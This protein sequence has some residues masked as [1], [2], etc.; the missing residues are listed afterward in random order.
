MADP[1]AYINGSRLN[2]RQ[3]LDDMRRR[4][5]AYAGKDPHSVDRCACTY[6]AGESVKRG[7]IVVVIAC[8]LCP[9]E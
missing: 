9:S 7:E 2:D 3:G 6:A 8:R 1:V 5:I 4:K